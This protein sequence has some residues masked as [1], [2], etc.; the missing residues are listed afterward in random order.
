MCM[1]GIVCTHGA[2]A[3]A[4]GGSRRQLRE[5]GWLV[6]RGMGEGEARNR[7]WRHGISGW[8][9]FS[10]CTCVTAANYIFFFYDASCEWQPPLSVCLS[11][12]P[13][14]GRGALL[15]PVAGSIL[16]RP[17]RVAFACRVAEFGALVPGIRFH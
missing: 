5:V 3:A 11:G 9:S 17:G 4:E 1:Y 13:Q 6:I 12:T 8:C 16:P 7:A 2:C 15:M 10:S 14:P